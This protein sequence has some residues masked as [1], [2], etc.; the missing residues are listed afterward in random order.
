VSAVTAEFINESGT[1]NQ[2]TFELF[3]RYRPTE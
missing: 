1:Y 2:E 3:V